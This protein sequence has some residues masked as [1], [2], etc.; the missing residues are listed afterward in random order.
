MPTKRSSVYADAVLNALAIGTI[1]TI[2]TLWSEVSVV[3]SADDENPKIQSGQV[4]YPLTGILHTAHT[5]IADIQNPLGETQG[6]SALLLWRAYSF[7]L[8]LPDRSSASPSIKVVATSTD[9]TREASTP[10]S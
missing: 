8:S 6:D 5:A 4:V 3:N 2:T 9:S 7:L 10:A 1:A